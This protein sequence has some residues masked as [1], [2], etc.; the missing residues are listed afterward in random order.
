MF[1]KVRRLH[2][3][4]FICELN[5][6]LSFVLILCLTDKYSCKI[7][8]EF[9]RYVNS[10]IAQCLQPEMA[11]SEPEVAGLLPETMTFTLM[12]VSEVA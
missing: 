11:A 9:S 2:N 5:F 3:S 4:L 12:I 7:R 10:V 8:E 1:I 6:H